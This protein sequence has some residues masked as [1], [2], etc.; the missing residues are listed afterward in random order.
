MKEENSAVHANEEINQHFYDSE[1]EISRPD[2]VQE[3]STVAKANAKINKEFYT[4]DDKNNIVPNGYMNNNTA[5]I[6]INRGK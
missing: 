2:L 6:Q 1:V 5:A 3:E 4:N